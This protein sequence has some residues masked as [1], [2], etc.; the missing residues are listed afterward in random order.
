M[1]DTEFQVKLERALTWAG[2][3]E[4]GQQCVSVTWELEDTGG[5]CS[6]CGWFHEGE[7]S[8]AQYHNPHDIACPPLTDELAMRLL[9]IT[10]DRCC[11][12]IFQNFDGV[13]VM[14]RTQ[15]YRVDRPQSPDDAYGFDEDQWCVALVNSVAALA[16]AEQG[17]Q[18]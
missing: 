9:R 4:P 12:V 2:I 16:E 6:H 1:N 7:L 8:V 10:A 15:K 5:R 3:W 18:G 17:K 11:E 14:I 13:Q